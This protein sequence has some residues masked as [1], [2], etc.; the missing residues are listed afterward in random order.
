MRIVKSML[1]AVLPALL[2]ASLSSSP[3]YAAGGDRIAGALTASGGQTVTLRG[4]VRHQALPKFDEGAVDPALHLGTMTL[5]TVPTPAQQKAL[6]Q[7][8]AQQQ[9]RKS[10]NYHKWLTPEQFADRFGLSANDMQKMAD[11]LQSQG[12]TRIQQAR[13]RNWISF[14][15]TALQVE[16]AFATEIHHYNVEGKLHYANVTPPSIPAALA[17]IVGGVRGLDDFHPKPM[18]IQHHPN[19]FYNG[20]FQAQFVAPGDVYTIY[21]VNGLYANGIDGTGQKLAVMGETDIYQADINNFRTGFGLSSIS[22]TTQAAAPNDIITSCS[23]PHFSYVLDGTDPGV[24][25][26]DLSESDLDLEWSGAV[27][28][29]AQLI[30]VNSTDVFTSFYYAIDNQDTLGETVISLSYGG[31]EFDENIGEANGLGPL[32]ETELMQANTEGIT[33]VNSAGDTGSAACDANNPGG[34]L[35][36]T[37][38]ATQG[39]AVSY[40][41]SSPEVTAVGGT[42]IPLADI[43][44]TYWGTTNAANGGT[45]LSYIPEQAWND[46]DEFVTYCQQNPGTFCENGNDTP[47]W[48]PIISEATAQEDIGIGTGGGGASNCAVQN[49][50]FSACISGFAQPTWQTVTISGQSTRMVPDVSFL[51]SPNFPGY[52]FCTQLSELGDSGSGSSCNPGGAAGI[53]DAL[54]LNYISVIGGT[55]VSAPVFAGMVTLLNQYLADGTSPGLGNVNGTL[56]TLAATPANGAFN[57]VLSGDNFVACQPGDPSVQPVAQQC[58][59]TGPSAGVIGYE[60]S[61]ADEA[62]SFNLVTGLGS[63][64]ANHLAV[65]W[66]ASLPAGFTLAPT[67]TSYQVTQGS[68]VDATVIV[69]L[70]GGFTGPVAFQCSDPAPASTCTAPPSVNATG[71]V[72]FNITTT[73][74]TAALNHP[75]GRATGIFYA[76]FLPGLLGILFTAGSRRRSLR[77]LRLLGLIVALGFTTLWMASCGGGS[78][79]GNTSNPGTPVGNYT[80]TVTATS[81]SSTVTSTFQ[82]DVVQ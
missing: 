8:L 63:V 82:L 42:A 9:D 75:S 56:Y 60:A 81:G 64:N 52:I 80:I 38:L 57:P 39:L 70:N 13:G 79:G 69:Q 30:F 65:A 59:S 18:G 72:S 7:L 58:P 14:T 40:P 51:A 33:F 19:Y 1:L 20:S 16:N 46:D 10:P 5:L 6:T 71:K 22:C 45:A 28:P 76:T 36:G 44:P 29:G 48:V 78:S 53:T 47:G 61:N 77:G 41:A 23:D 25:A 55:S 43:S 74:P 37:G 24:R 54:G 11:W 15:G 68:P 4:N 2:I 12:F 26:G 49:A 17:G 34:T 67:A 35:T 50:D 31:C 3:S 73:A 66:A 21:D 62:T 27:A 32:F